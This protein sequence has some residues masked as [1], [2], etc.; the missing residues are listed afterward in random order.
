MDLDKP[1]YHE[2][3]SILLQD[4]KTYRTVKKNLSPRIEKRL[5]CFVWNLFECK[6]LP[7]SMYKFSRS[8]DSIL[9]R[10]HDLPKIHKPNLPLRPIVSF[11]ISATY[12]GSKFLKNILSPLVGN[13]VHT[14]K[15]S[16]EFVELI[17][18]INIHDNESQ[19]SFKCCKF[20]HFDTTWNSQSYCTW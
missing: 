1:E 15:N 4:P 10:M 2:K 20:I 9:S 14:V 19:V 12:E 11:V 16:S 17:E 13:T 3:V 18:K 8:T 6:K 5:N 7:F